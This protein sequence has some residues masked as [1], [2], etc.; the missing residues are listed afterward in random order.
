MP[1]RDEKGGS[2]EVARRI[3]QDKTSNFMNAKSKRKEDK[4]IF[5]A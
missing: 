1:V 3:K 5:Q 4:L 2:I